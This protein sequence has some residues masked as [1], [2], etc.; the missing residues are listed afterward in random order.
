MNYVEWLRIRNCVRMTA[1]ILAIMVVLAIILRISLARNMSPESWISRMTSEPGTK[2][3][4]SVLPDGTK[5]TLI[6][7]PTDNS[8]VIVDDRGDAGQHIVVTEPAGHAHEEHSDFSHIGNIV[9]SHTSGG[10]TTTT[11]DTKGS[12]PMLYYMAFADVV[13]LIVATILAAPFARE[14]DGHLEVAMTKPVSRV[15]YALGSIGVDAVGILAAS[16]LTIVALYLCQLLFGSARLDFTGINARAIVM[17]AALPL[18]WYALLCAGTT[19]LSRSYVAVL[20]FAWPVALLIAGLTQLEPNNIVALVVRNVAWALSRLDPLTYVK[21]AEHSES[22]YSGPD[23][24][25]RLSILV[26]L[27]VVYSA[28]AV[29]QWQRVEA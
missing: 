15:R 21:F 9:S 22:S 11:I 1:I 10:T 19:L 26:L 6:Y 18:A 7:D 13:A 23:F 16:L 2:I 27:F 29:W 3:T 28:I 8:H 25:A 5:R 14:I 12:V 17:G 4:H 20:G 24:G